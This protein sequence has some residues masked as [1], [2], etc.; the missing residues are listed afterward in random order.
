MQKPEAH[1]S[2]PNTPGA[3]ATATPRASGEQPRALLPSADTMESSALS[4]P[5]DTLLSAGKPADK[6]ELM[7]EDRLSGLE[8][9]LRELEGRLAVLERKKT[10][11]AADPRQKP[12]LWIAFLIALVVVFQLLQR[13]R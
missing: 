8:E 4:E 1:D 6:L 7:I 5:S 3:S 9:R 10:S 12:W 2:D 11:A 13:V